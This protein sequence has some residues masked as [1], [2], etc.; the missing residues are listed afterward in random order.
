LSVTA[1]WRARSG[2]S[3]LLSDAPPQPL[4]V[5]AEVVVGDVGRA[6]VVQ[7]G[8]VPAF[9]D[10]RAHPLELGVDGCAVAGEHT[11]VDAEPEAKV[12]AQVL[13]T[14]STSMPACTSKGYSVSIPASS[15]TG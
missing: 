3:L 15:H 12:P 6:G 9:L 2:P 7:P 14:S 10:Q 8:H 1:G 4:H 5:V 13:R 11:L